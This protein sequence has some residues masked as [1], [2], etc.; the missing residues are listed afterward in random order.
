MPYH[1]GVKEYL[2]WAD[3]YSSNN[4]KWAITLDA[5]YDQTPIRDSV[6]GKNHFWVWN[7]LAKIYEFLRRHV[8]VPL[9]VE[10]IW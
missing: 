3:A 8:Q 7:L 1:K 9:L 5:C 2:V 6:I 4:Q 10:A